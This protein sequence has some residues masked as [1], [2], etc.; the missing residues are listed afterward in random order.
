[1][2]W[3]RATPVQHRWPIH[4]R[5]HLQAREQVS[6]DPVH[7]GG[8]RHPD[9]TAQLA[10]LELRNLA[11]ERSPKTASQQ[12]GNGFGKQTGA[13]RLE[14]LTQREDLRQPPSRRDGNLSP[15][16]V[17]DREK[18]WN[19]SMNASRVWWP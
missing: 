17:R 18:A 16:R 1:M 5:S 3:P 12:A 14:H 8:K 10:A 4:S 11:P 2:G 19:G 7:P 6:Q 15:T 9:A 13:D